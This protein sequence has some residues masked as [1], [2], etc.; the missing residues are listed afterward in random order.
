MENTSRDIEVLWQDF[1]QARDL[2]LVGLSLLFRSEHSL[3][4]L[5]SMILIW[6]SLSDGLPRRGDEKLEDFS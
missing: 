3:S 1:A 6:L 4:R 5:P 2:M